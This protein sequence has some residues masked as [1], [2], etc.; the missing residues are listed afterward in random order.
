MTLIPAFDWSYIPYGHNLRDPVLSPFF[1]P[2]NSLPPF[3]GFVAAE[4]DILAHENWQLACRLAREGGEAHGTAAA[5]RE[6]PDPK[7]EDKKWSVCG[8]EDVKSESGQIDVL[9][10]TGKPDDRFGFEENWEDGGVKWMLIPD[11]LHGFDNK[12]VREYVGGENTIEDAEA[13]TK[14]MMDRLG[15]WLKTIV[16]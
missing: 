7:S 16:W 8:S 2:R 13:K 12:H 3:V 10:E 11:V 4:L 15:I 1:A 9:D 14:V 5:S 6:I